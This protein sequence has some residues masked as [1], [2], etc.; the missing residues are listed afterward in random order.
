MC[1]SECLRGT[2][3]GPDVPQSSEDSGGAAGA[4]HRQNR[5]CSRG[6]AALVSHDRENTENQEVDARHWLVV[7]PRMSTL[8]VLPTR[9]LMQPLAKSKWPEV[10]NLVVTRRRYEEELEGVR[11]TPSVLR[12]KVASDA[13][14]TVGIRQDRVN[15]LE[16]LSVQVNSI[17]KT[18]DTGY[19]KSETG[20]WEQDAEL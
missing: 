14:A 15:L 20:I 2:K 16:T 6:D 4:G 8:V 18:G 17:E 10:E 5:G 19:Q 12:G 3:T 13:E 1:N 11:E 9:S 7:S